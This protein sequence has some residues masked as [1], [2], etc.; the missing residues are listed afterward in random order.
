MKQAPP[1]TVRRSADGALL[2]RELRGEKHGWKLVPSQS[3]HTVFFGDHEID[4][5]WLQW[6]IIWCPDANFHEQDNIRRAQGRP[7]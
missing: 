3:E 7:A 6:P 5:A 1:G 2:V 4:P